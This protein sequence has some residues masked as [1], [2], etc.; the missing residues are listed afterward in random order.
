MK[1][2][3][4]SKLYDTDNGILILQDIGITG[5]SLYKQ[6]KNRSF[7]LYDGDQITPL[8]LD[9]AAELIRRAGDP[10]LLRYLEVKPSPKGCV[11]LAVTLDRYNK[12]NR[13]AATR[14]VSMKSIIESYI[15][16]LPEA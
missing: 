3:V 14:G 7:Y 9:E 12:L 10:D 15:D 8:E 4:G 11:T 13:I 5:L 6:P 16:S 1:K 2:R